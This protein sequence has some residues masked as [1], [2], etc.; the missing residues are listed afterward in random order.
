MKRR[1]TIAVLITSLALT[2]GLVGCGPK[3][4]RVETGVRTVCTYGEVLTDTV[5]AIEVPANKVAS[6]GVKNKT[7]TC[8]LH[9][10]LEKLYA[11]AQAAIAAGDLDTAKAKLAEIVKSD[12]S[13]RKAQEQL[14][15][16]S[17]GKSP[18]EDTATSTPVPNG[19]GS[20]GGGN[21]GGNA[22]NPG[23]GGSGPEPEPIGPVAS[24]KTW[25][26]DKLTG[27]TAT[28]VLA[29]VFSLTREYMPGASSPS[30]SLVIVVEEY[31][32]AKDAQAAVTKIIGASYSADVSN[33]TVEGRKVRFGTDG[34]RFATASWAEGSLLIVIEG[35][36]AG[37]E[38]EK[39]KSHLLS[40][41]A[42][43][44]K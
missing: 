33:A 30:A 16:I 26:P 13:F 43:I 24:L 23:E 11:E 27:Y 37:H 18:D 12:A 20:S 34:S 32:K 38:P 10:R 39:L 8:S 41:V 25:V 2:I 9:L 21:S 1:I 28:P 14:S 15:A 5:K 4:V 31:G 3:K 19:G 35:S 40:L 44:V 6:Y 36:S 7:I 22:E 29:D 17:V 42:E